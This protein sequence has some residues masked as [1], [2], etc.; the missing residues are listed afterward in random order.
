MAAQSKCFAYLRV[1]GKGQIDGDGFPRQ[2][3]AI[4]SY[5]DT[6]G[7]KVI[8]WFEEQGISGTKDLE[9]RPALQELMIALHANGTKVIIIEKLDRLA[10]DLMVQETI[11]GDLRKSGFELISVCEPDLCS[12]DP[13]RKLIRQVFGAISEYE[14]SMIVL[15][16]RASRERARIK[17]GR[18]EGRKPF[19]HTAD[20]QATIARMQELREQ[21][22]NDLQIAAQLTAEGLKPRKADAWSSAVIARILNRSAANV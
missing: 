14:R 8:H 13:S 15:K 12:D 4:K 10:R 11:I 1:S 17:H 6:H 18:C 16:L 7:L 5:A 22:R 19:G 21:G 20:E 9:N 3:T 2:R